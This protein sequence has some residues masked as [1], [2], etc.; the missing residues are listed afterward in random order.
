MTWTPYAVTAAAALA[1][2][3]AAT[4]IADRI[5]LRRLRRILRQ[6]EPHSQQRGGVRNTAKRAMPQGGPT[7]LPAGEPRSAATRAAGEPVRRRT[8]YSWSNDLDLFAT[9]TL[10][11]IR[12]LPETTEPTR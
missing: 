9:L 12:R 6:W 1:T 3:A 2:W 7:F 4:V 8:P 11:E 10:D 5:R